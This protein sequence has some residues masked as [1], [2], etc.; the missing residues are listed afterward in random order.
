VCWSPLN[1][2]QQARY[3]VRSNSK[4]IH[5]KL[6]HGEP[7]SIQGSD[8]NRHETGW[9]NGDAGL[10]GDSTSGPAIAA[11]RA[12]NA[13]LWYKSRN[14]SQISSYQLSRYFLSNIQTIKNANKTKSFVGQKIHVYHSVVGARTHAQV[15]P[16]G[17]GR[18]G[19]IGPSLPPGGLEH[20]GHGKVL[21]LSFFSASVS[22][23]YLQ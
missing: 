20:Q 3:S 16:T 12:E 5:F 7:A 18:M 17:W 1:G 2:A 8:T 6:L 22:P 4:L 19:F 11:E 15:E 14:S 23:L 21:L 13:C 10:S 9:I